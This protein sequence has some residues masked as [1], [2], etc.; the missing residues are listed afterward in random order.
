MLSAK[1]KLHVQKYRLYLASCKRDKD[2]HESNAITNE[3]ANSVYPRCL[4]SCSSF[5]IS[6]SRWKPS[7][8]SNA[9]RPTAGSLSFS[10]IATATV[11]LSKLTCNGWMRANPPHQDVLTCQ[12]TTFES[13]LPHYQN[14]ERVS[15]YILFVHVVNRTIC[16]MVI[17]LYARVWLTIACKNMSGIYTAFKM[18]ASIILVNTSF[19]SII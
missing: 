8:K 4:A 18:W 14:D 11:S 13:R 10:W 9:A 16:V 1:S 7:S 15:M 12:H 17:W 3:S 19:S 2:P 5:T 6:S